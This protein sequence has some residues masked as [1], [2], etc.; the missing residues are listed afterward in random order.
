MNGTLVDYY[1]SKIVS[2]TMEVI[3]EPYTYEEFIGIAAP[4]IKSYTIRI[5]MTD[6]AIRATNI[7]PENLH[8]E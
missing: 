5:K 4:K 6:G 7:L 2:L 3:E 1:P 8:F